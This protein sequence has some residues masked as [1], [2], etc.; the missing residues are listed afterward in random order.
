MDFSLT[1]KYGELQ[2][3]RLLVE[4]AAHG[5]LDTVVTLLESG[6]SVDADEHNRALFYASK[7]YMTPLQMACENGYTACVE[8]LIS[9]GAD[10]NAKDRFDVTAMHVA[11]AKGNCSCLR[12]L[13]NANA[14]CSLPTKCSKKGCYTAV[15]YLGGTTPLHLAAANNHVECVRELIQYG[16]DYNAVDELGRTSLYIAAQSGF[17][18]CVLAHLKN[19]IGR[20]ILSLPSYETMD[21]PLHF[22]VSR[23]MVDCVRALL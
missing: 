19:A 22:A 16:A 17:G 6:I 21:T 15:P 5:D 9:H 11:A 23:G 3:E 7:N 14:E 4:A 18:D 8:V 2:S 1:N 10:V 12:A 20:D 13:L